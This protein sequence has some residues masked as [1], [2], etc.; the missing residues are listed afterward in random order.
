MS[1]FLK[2]AS[3]KGS[4]KEL[5]KRIASRVYGLFSVCISAVLSCFA[6]LGFR[7]EQL[8]VWVFKVRVR[9]GRWVRLKVYRGKD[10]G[11]GVIGLEH[12]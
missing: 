5:L 10:F 12:G 6:F 2:R 11:F 4:R 1:R 7:V 3:L 9:P 8:R